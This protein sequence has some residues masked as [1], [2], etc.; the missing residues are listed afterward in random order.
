MS[1][2]FTGLVFVI[3]VLIFV[4]LRTKT[5]GKF[6]IKVTDII[7]GI[8]PIILWLLV[9]GKISELTLGELGVKL[10]K[11]FEKAIKEDVTLKRNLLA[12]GSNSFPIGVKCD[13]R[14]EGDILKNKKIIGGAEFHDYVIIKKDCKRDSEFWGILNFRDLR[15]VFLE[16]LQENRNGEVFLLWVKSKSISNLKKNIPSFILA[17][18]AITYKT[19]KLTALE[20]MENL[21]VDYLP[22]VDDDNSFLGVVTRS[23]LTTSFLINIG[24]SLKK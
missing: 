2:Y 15:E 5:Q 6:E 8:L 14:I 17:D 20:K 23:K 9:S 13:Y 12:D 16:S 4:F 22:V 10:H 3:L 18:N 7:M 24:E 11:E 19:D 21:N 1:I